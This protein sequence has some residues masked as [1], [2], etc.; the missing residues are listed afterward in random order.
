MDINLFRALFL[1]CDWRLLSRKLI[2]FPYFSNKLRFFIYMYFE[3]LGYCLM[4]G[5]TSEETTS[6]DTHINTMIW[7]EVVSQDL[8]CMCNLSCENKLC[9]FY[10]ASVDSSVMY[11]SN[12]NCCQF[13]TILRQIL[14]GLP[15]KVIGLQRK[16]I[17]SYLKFSWNEFPICNDPPA[18]C[19]TIRRQCGICTLHCEIWGLWM[20]K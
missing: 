6:D 17:C 2:L 16:Y 11:A 13:F 12:R 4:V 3:F 20:Q 7:S 8:I 1:K 18:F 19:L 15:F 14:I 10:C 9:K 5:S